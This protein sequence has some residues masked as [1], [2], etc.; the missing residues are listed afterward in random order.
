MPSAPLRRA[1]GCRRPLGGFPQGSEG[2]DIA[3]GT[4]WRFLNELKQELKG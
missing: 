1:W 4:D 3:Q 2:E